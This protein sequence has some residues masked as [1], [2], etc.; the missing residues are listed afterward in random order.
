MLV[1]SIFTNNFMDDVF[2]DMFMEP[3]SSFGS[4]FKNKAMMNADV[5]E[6]DNSYA[7]ELEL[8]GYKKEEVHAELEDGYLTISA[9][10]SEDKDEKDKAGKYVRKERY[11]G[12]CKRSF[13][14]GEDVTKND[15]NAE[16]KDGILKIDIPKVEPKKEI[17]KKE[18][19]AIAG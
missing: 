14:V 2:N 17:D 3:F 10:H 7:L 4:D 13:Y 1:P 16:F 12:K 5:K 9:D 6:Y 19:I 8:P 18:Y 15:I 11:V